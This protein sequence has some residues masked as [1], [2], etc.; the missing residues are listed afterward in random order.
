MIQ[1]LS[2][3][4]RVRDD[5][6][7]KGR[8]TDSTF[9]EFETEDAIIL[10]GDP[11]M[12]KTTFF[13]DASKGDYSTVRDF[14]IDPCS[15]AGKALFLDALDEYR[16]LATGQDATSELAKQLCALNKPKFRL[17]CRAADWFGSPDQ[18]ALRTASASGRIMVLEL[19]P[20]T[21]DEILKA[22]GGIVPDPILFLSEAESAGL[23]NLLANPQ[24]L[25]LVARA[26]GTEK[27][28]RNKFEAYDIGVS[29]L[30]K[31]MNIYHT[32][33]GLPSINPADLRKAAGAIASTLL[34]SNSVGISR[35]EPAEGAGYVGL[36]VVPYSKT[37]EL[38]AVLRRRLFISS[39]VDRFEP[40]HRT[41]GEFLAAEDL[42]ARVGNGLP[43]D[44]VMSLICAVDGRPVS[45]LR[46]L[47]AWLMCKL[48]HLAAGYVDRD[49]YGVATYG[50]ASVL[51][52]RA[53]CAIWA[54]LRKLRDPWFLANE[55]DRGS[56]RGLANLDTIKIIREILQDV[57]TGV[58]L[59]IT[60]LEAIANSTEYGLNAIIR[61]MALDKN[62]N[63]WIRSTALKA[64]TRS[65]QSEKAML[66]SIDYEL[67]LATDD[68]AALELR[69]DLLRQTQAWGRLPARVLSI[70]REA[71]SA[72]E[73]RVF[74]RFY[75]LS[76]FLSDG[77]LNEILDGAS[78]VL[79]N[80]SRDAFDQ[81]ALFEELFKRRLGN[82]TPITPAQLA[83]WLQ[84]LSI[85]RDRHPEKILTPLK[86]RFEKDPSLFKSV[87]ELLAD[88]MVIPVRSFSFFLGVQL[89]KLLPATVWPVSQSE[90]FLN[91]A[92]QDNNPERGADFFGMYLA[93]FPSESA[94][95]ELAEAGF[96]F[97]SR[98]PDV[99][100]VLGNWNV[101]KIEKW[102]KDQYKR[103]K[104]DSRKLAANRAYNIS[105]LT[106]RLSIIRSGGDETALAWAARIY[107][108]VLYDNENVSDATERLVT[109][110]NEEIAEAFVEGFIRY[111]EHR[112]IPT[113]QAV[114]DSWRIR[115]IPY[116]HFLLCLSVYLRLNGGMSVPKEALSACIAA[117]VTVPSI[118][119]SIP[120]WNDKLSGWLIDQAAQNP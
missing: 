81:W 62:E 91:C 111:V 63:T 51:P 88:G 17:S 13:K 33:R 97:L 9:A 60:A 28:P 54:G 55:D 58:H 73:Q 2:R 4:L 66:E 20:L 57:G 29:E 11:G 61:K 5:G 67:A 27:K 38:D 112:S 3:H 94:S 70:L 10:L 1:P 74:G 90:F 85:G 89:W 26:W 22:V 93:W 49:P 86:S 43:I 65:V 46:G 99:A 101:C 64:L 104:K 37:N 107:L 50:D 77:D 12:G 6:T 117:V 7:G 118:G 110:T 115:K 52:P 116:T 39:E 105:Y 45:S 69:V 79:T 19:C 106:P 120:G 83:N 16:S 114:V 47:F 32:P 75:S 21:R 30:L 76:R 40:I 68:A 72:K 56:F 102:R 15:I 109:L 80:E 95:S 108:G 71:A 59:K 98:R 35:T 44:R 18:E 14:L 53:Q 84:A 82:P 42:A 34:L 100:K 87:F 31:E 92:E 78:Q 119:D 48:S 96:Q 23:G 8:D 41:I 103:R 36:S 25:E 24:T 113:L